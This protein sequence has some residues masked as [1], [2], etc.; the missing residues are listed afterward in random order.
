MCDKI[1]YKGF[2]HAY[3][4]MQ[5]LNRN[6]GFELKTAYICPDCGQWHLTSMEHSKYMR[7]MKK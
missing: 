5:W 3:T 6:K 2:D 4:Q 7:I 1:K